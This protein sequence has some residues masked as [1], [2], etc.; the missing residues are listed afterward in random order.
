MES[1]KNGSLTALAKPC[2]KGKKHLVFNLLRQKRVPKTDKKQKK[3][4]QNHC[5]T[6]KNTN[7]KIGCKA[8]K[9]LLAD[10]NPI[11]LQKNLLA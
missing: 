5:W 10:K 8:K 6:P 7:L 1:S 3:K 9:K 11:V 4:E 2:P